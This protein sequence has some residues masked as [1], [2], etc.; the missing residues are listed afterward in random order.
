MVLAAPIFSFNAASR[1]VV[2]TDV[3]RSDGARAGVGVG[4][5]CADA[6]ARAFERGV[7]LRLEGVLLAEAGAPGNANSSPE[8]SAMSRVL[9]L[10]NVNRKEA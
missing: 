5:F 1:G 7:A 8:N 9:K 4:D 2:I 3:L 10:V 6:D